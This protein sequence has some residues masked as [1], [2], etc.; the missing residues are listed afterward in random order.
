MVGRTVD[1][2]LD[3]SASQNMLFS[4]K[5]SKVSKRVEAGHVEF[6]MHAM[7]VPNAGKFVRSAK[8]STT[9]VSGKGG[10]SGIGGVPPQQ[11]YY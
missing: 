6:M 10:L 3:C 7:A 5:S 9:E 4:S 1:V 11:Q 8:C 2:H